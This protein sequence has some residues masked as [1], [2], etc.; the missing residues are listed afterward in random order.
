[1]FSSFGRVADVVIKRHSVEVNPVGIIGN[2]FVYFY[3]IA[4]AM[5]AAA[6]IKN[7]TIDGVFYD[8]SFGARRELVTPP[9]RKVVMANVGNKSRIV[10]NTQL[11]GHMKLE[12]LA[13]DLHHFTGKVMNGRCQIT[14]FRMRRRECCQAS[15]TLETIL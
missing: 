6:H 4:H 7:M 1:M 3:D 10:S 15:T 2:A 8:C 9:A 5:E 12:R 14:Y 11:L 13:M